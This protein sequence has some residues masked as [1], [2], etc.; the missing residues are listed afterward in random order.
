MTEFESFLANIE[1]EAKFLCPSPPSSSSPSSSSSSSSSPLLEEEERQ[2]NEKIV[3]SNLKTRK[4]PNTHSSR[5]KGVSYIYE[6]R[7]WKT[8]VYLG[9]TPK[10]VG[11]YDTEEKAARAY[12]DY[13]SKVTG[14]M[15]IVNDVP[16]TQTFI[17]LNNTFK[18]RKRSHAE[19]TENTYTSSPSSSTGPEKF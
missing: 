2:K 6:K 8:T 1:E 13:V 7:R 18:R 9:K 5:F 14:K 19:Y 12:N 4:N 17:P 16:D 15:I 10:Y 11:L 3:V